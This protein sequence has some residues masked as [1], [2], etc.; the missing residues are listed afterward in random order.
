MQAFLD[1]APKDGVPRRE[2]WVGGEPEKGPL[3][4]LVGPLIELGIVVSDSSGLRAISWQD[5]AAWKSATN[6][7]LTA[8]EGKALIG[9]SMAYMLE[10]NKSLSQAHVSPYSG[11]VDHHALAARRR[12]RRK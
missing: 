2:H 8:W 12:N 4:Y 6:S 3:E 11:E 10:H 1:T 5:I 9:L 7:Q